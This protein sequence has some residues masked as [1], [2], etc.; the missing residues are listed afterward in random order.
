MVKFGVAGN[1]E[2][3][4]NEGYKH[5]EEAAKWC[6][7]RG[8]D[9]FEY[10]FGKGVRMTKEKAEKI[11][12]AFTQYGLEMTAHAPYYINFANPDPE[13]IHNSIGY[14]LQTQRRTNCRTPRHTRQGRTRAGGR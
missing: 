10:S 9:V 3:F 14:V 7:N 8:I 11:G 12:A 2:S 5:T 6:Y 4:Y 13:K 1:S